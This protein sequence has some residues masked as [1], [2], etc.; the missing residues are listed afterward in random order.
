[1]TDCSEA[2]ANHEKGC[3]SSHLIGTCSKRTETNA[4]VRRSCWWIRSVSTCRDCGPRS[5]RHSASAS[6][7]NDPVHIFPWQTAA[8][9]SKDSSHAS[10]T[11]I[12]HP[13]LTC[14]KGRII[15]SGKFLSSGQPSGTAAGS[16][17]DNLRIL[18]LNPDCHEFAMPNRSEQIK[19]LQNR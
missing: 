1:M 15:R 7:P 3:R 2:D 17:R 9:E 5:E 13:K 8:P 6:R 14:V 11:H 4:A 12:I 10:V 19:W 18:L 16:W